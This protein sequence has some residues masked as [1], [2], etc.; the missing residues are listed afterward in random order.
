MKRRRKTEKEKEEN[1]WKRKKF[2][3]KGKYLVIGEKEKVEEKGGK[4]LEKENLWSLEKKKKEN[5]F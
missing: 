2:F 5:I 1:I 3:G 4:Y